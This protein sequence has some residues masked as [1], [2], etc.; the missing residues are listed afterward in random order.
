[1]AK[2]ID[3]T[4]QKFNRFL[5]LEYLG[6]SKWLCRCS[7]GTIKIVKGSHLK[8]GSIQ[9]CGCLFRELASNR[10]SKRNI[11]HNLFNSNKRLYACWR[12]LKLR[13]YC[14]NNSSYKTYGGRGITVCDEW[15]N[16]FKNFYDWA[17]SN[18]YDKNA[19]RGECTID[20]IDVNGNYEPSNCRW[21]NMK[22]QSNNKTNNRLIQYN[23]EIKTLSQWSDYFGIRDNLIHDRL[24]AGYSFE[25]ATKKID[26]RTIKSKAKAVS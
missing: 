11:T 5:V 17:M 26:Y 23:G 12:S 14:K 18:G 2:F 24:K 10:I 13:C 6:N 15:K 3:L 1:M 20:R 9:S 21:T 19:K 8:N 4:G 25:E 22:E 7:C 16:D